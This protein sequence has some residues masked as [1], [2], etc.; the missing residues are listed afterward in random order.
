MK[1]LVKYLAVAAVLVWAAVACLPDDKL[2]LVFCDVGQGDA[3]LAR[4]RNVQILVDAGPNDKVTKCLA[5]NVP[6][7]DRKIEVVVLT[8]PESDHIGG[9]GYVTQSYSVVQ[10]VIGEGSNPKWEK[11]RKLAAEKGI[12]IGAGQ[13]GEV[14]KSGELKFRVGEAGSG[15]ANDE[16]LAGEL[17]F[18]KFKAVL[19]GDAEARVLGWASEAQILKVPHHGSRE[20]VTTELLEKIKPKLAVIS[21]G[22][23]NYGHP[24][25]ETLAI[26]RLAGV[27][28]IR[29]DETGEVE[30]V[31]DGL[32]W[33]VK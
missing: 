7:Y 5:Q 15:S 32:R 30:V 28:I 19:S 17:E 1:V 18:G 6:F 3:I 8:H 29:T 11:T 23:N 27:R 33:W 31:T 22:K 16:S 24:N 14:I 13:P 26:L 12:T 20:A 25:E 9:L 4:Y 2:H 21:V 10:I